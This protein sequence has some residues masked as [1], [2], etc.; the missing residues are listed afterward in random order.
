MS[1]IDPSSIDPNSIDTPEF[2]GDRAVIYIYVFTGIQIVAV[3]L[4][5]WAR[6]LTLR[7][8]GWD[9]WLVGASLLSTI[10]YGAASISK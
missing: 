5:F 3:A 10:V 2:T 8:W 7:S 9:D 6:A 4:R 1:L